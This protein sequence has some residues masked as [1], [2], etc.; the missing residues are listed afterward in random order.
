M[1]NYRRTSKPKQN[2]SKKTTVFQKTVATI[3][4]ILGLITTSITIMNA[5]DNNKNTKKNLRQID[6]NHCQRNSKESLRKT[7]V[8]IR[9]IT[10]LK[11]KHK[12]VEEKLSSRKDK[13]VLS[14]LIFRA[15]K[16]FFWSFQSSETKGIALDKFDEII[17]RFNFA[18]E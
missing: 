9:K 1:S 14:F 11:K 2:T 3:S 5:L 13:F 17:G 18:L 8:L 16:S 15:I 12:W 7:L 4:S 6:D 10:L